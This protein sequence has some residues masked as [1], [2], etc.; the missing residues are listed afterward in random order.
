MSST[1]PSSAGS[2]SIRRRIQARAEAYTGEPQEVPRK[3]SEKVVELIKM[4]YV[5]LK[6][7]G[8]YWKNFLLGENIEVIWAPTPDPNDVLGY[9]YWVP[10]WVAAFFTDREF[11][12]NI[13]L[14]ETRR[15]LRKL[16]ESSREQLLLMTE[17]ML[18]DDL[19]P[20]V[21]DIYKR[22]LHESHVLYSKEEPD[23]GT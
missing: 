14:E 11:D 2:E 19:G 5:P 4:G 18:M 15:L 21:R 7:L 13:S 17:R 1:K 6:E 16:R 10:A 9:A 3:R 22:C 20:G 12:P 23:D 8:N